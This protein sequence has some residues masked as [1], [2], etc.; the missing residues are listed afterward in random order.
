MLWQQSENL[1]YSKLDW[2]SK[3]ELRTG[4]CTLVR[5]TELWNVKCPMEKSMEEEYGRKAFEPKDEV[6][7]RNIKKLEWVVNK[8]GVSYRQI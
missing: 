2:C 4:N 8:K 7:Y 6:K 3:Q 5:L 1:T